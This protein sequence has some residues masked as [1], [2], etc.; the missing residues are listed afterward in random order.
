MMDLV[1]FG[2]MVAILVLVIGNAYFVGSEVAITAARRSRI[3][4]LADMGDKRAKIVKLLH[5]EPTR[6][7]AVTQIGITLVS[8]ALGYIGMDAFKELLSPA[9]TAMLAM[10]MGSEQAAS[11]G[12]IVGLTMGF[13]IVSFLHVVGGELAPKV[14]AYHKAEALSCGVAWS[15]NALYKM[16]VPV[17]WLMNHASNWLLTFVGQGDIVGH[18]GGHGHD[19]SSMSL[20]ELTLVVNASASSG[21]IQKDMGRMLMGVLDMDEE[22]VEDA[23]IPKPDVLSL[24]SSATLSDALG[25]F[26]KTSHYSYPVLD[27]D[28]VAGTIFM[29]RL[30][31]L[32]E[33]NKGNLP[34]LLQQPIQ[35]LM[36]T[37]PLILP[38]NVKLSRAWMEFRDNRRQFGVVVNEH[39]SMVGILTPADI[40]SRLVGRFPG[41]EILNVPENVHK[42][43]GSQWEIAGSAR[44]FDLEM[45]LNFPFPR[46][47]GYVTIGGLVFSRLGRVPEVGDVV[48]VENGR[49]QI[50]EIEDLRV[51]KVLFQILAVNENGE[52]SLADQE[53]PAGS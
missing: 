36:R 19:S 31:R 28:K 40:V 50:L 21:T 23:M 44:V 34:E 12:G 29:K 2:K 4:Q 6:F 33:E 22:T 5:D 26:A 45:A 35:K 20:D 38:S 30:V 9:F 24:T 25:I 53:S 15:V 37:D 3:K 39:G 13:I 32:M 10:F 18:G 7:Y 27:G 52:W 48:Q 17:I 51:V 43:K 11:W 46:G 49:L 14:L 16:W 42:L 8:M 1:L 47:S 41:D